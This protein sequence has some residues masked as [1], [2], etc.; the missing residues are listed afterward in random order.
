MIFKKGEVIRKVKESEIADALMQEVNK[1][2]AESDG[3]T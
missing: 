3:Q 1:M 2:V